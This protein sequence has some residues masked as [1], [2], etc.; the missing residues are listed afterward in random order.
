MIHFKHYIVTILMYCVFLINQIV[1]LFLH[2]STSN[3]LVF[4]LWVCIFSSCCFIQSSVMLTY[5]T[6]IILVD[7]VFFVFFKGCLMLFVH[8]V[9]LY[10]IYILILFCLSISV[11]FLFYIFSIEFHFIC[12]LSTFWSICSSQ[13]KYNTIHHKCTKVILSYMNRLSK[14]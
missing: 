12:V 4:Y 9:F 1:F 3:F 6:T 8:F 7:P 5:C 13:L 2:P 10:L 14:Y 11:C